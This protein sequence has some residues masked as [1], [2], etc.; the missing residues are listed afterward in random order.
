MLKSCVSYVA[1]SREG[2]VGV[3]RYFAMRFRQ[4]HPVMPFSAH[5]DNMAGGIV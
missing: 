4:I 5:M 1:F 2:H 3:F